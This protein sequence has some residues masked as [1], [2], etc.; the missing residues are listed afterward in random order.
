[1]SAIKYVDEV[2]P[3]TSLDKFEAWKDLRYDVL[4]HGDDWKGSKLYGDL[5]KKLNSVGVDLVF[6]LIYGTSSTK[7]S[8][9]LDLVLEN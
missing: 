1:M 3:Q 8:Q 2:V 6:F 4:F 9:V 5:E 7:L